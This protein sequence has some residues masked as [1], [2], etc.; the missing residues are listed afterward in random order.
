MKRRLFLAGAAATAAAAFLTPTTVTVLRGQF[1]E[2]RQLFR[3]YEP[4][5]YYSAILGGVVEVPAG[6][7]TDFSSVPRVLFAYLIA[8]GTAYEAA[9]IHDWLYTVQAFNGKS[10]ERSVADDVFSEAIK[11]SEDTKAPSWLMWLA[12]RVGGRGSWKGAGPAQPPDVTA[13]IEMEA[14]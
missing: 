7:V 9:V 5:R 8:G 3:L 11:A 12:V 6:Y 1:R 4:V 13:A 10:I 14:P 2:G